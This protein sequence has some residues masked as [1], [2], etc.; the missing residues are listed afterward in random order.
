MNNIWTDLGLT[1]FLHINT[2]KFPK[3]EVGLDEKPLWFSNRHKPT[4][5]MVTNLLRSLLLCEI[6]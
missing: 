6:G 4:W 2:R 1:E 5:D 3:G